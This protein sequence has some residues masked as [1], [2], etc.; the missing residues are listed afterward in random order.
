MLAEE[1][2]EIVAPPAAQILVITDGEGLDIGAGVVGR[3]AREVLPTAVDYTTRSLKAKMRSANR[4]GVRWVLLMNADEAAR[5]VVQLK[6]MASSEQVE[7]A[8]S[9]LEE[10]LTKRAIALEETD[11]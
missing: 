11:R 7:V 4:T 3:V 10:A 9:D 6:E 5:K 1:G 8:W 2:I